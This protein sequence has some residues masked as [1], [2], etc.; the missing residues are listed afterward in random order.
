[1]ELGFERIDKLSGNS[2]DV[3]QLTV[4]DSLKISAGASYALS[5]EL[6]GGIYLAW[7]QA[8]LRGRNYTPDPNRLE[9][10]GFGFYLNGNYEFGRGWS[11][12]P[13]LEFATSHLNFIR[14]E[15]P[16]DWYYLAL[17]PFA[18]ECSF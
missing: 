2:D 17:H 14:N 4:V 1:M 3:Y 8:D 11:Y 15:T 7:Q 9:G 5:D 12:T 18:A 10:I 13:R 6:D 16:A